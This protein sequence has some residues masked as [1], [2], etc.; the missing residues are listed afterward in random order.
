MSETAVAG[1]ESVDERSSVETALGAARRLCLSGD[2][3]S[4]RGSASPS[5][6]SCFL[7]STMVGSNL[8]HPQS[9]RRN[10]RKR[11]TR[12]NARRTR[13]RIT[14]PLRQSW[15]NCGAPAGSAAA[16][17]QFEGSR[18]ITLCASPPPPRHPKLDQNAPDMDGFWF[19]V[20]IM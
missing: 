4:S 1:A 7:N 5:P 11:Y 10:R 12:E 17:A 6:L 8:C 13:A 16:G 14:R 20:A 19:S 3:R 18:R 2:I 9:K 15:S